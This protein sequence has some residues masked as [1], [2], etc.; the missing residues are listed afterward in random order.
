MAKV[1][2]TA[3]DVDSRRRRGKRVVDCLKRL[4][5]MKLARLSVRAH[6]IPV[7]K[8][9]RRV[10]T[11]LH[12][13]DERTVADRVDETAWDEKRLALL[14]LVADEQFLEAPR[15][16]CFFNILRPDTWL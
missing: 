3:L 4:L 13:I 6:A 10:R 7:V 14:R 1:E 15:L 11:L 9:K 16:D 2:E 12:F 8:P 5:D